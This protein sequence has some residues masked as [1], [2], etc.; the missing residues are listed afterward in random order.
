MLRK[1]KEHDHGSIQ[2]NGQINASAQSISLATLAPFLTTSNVSEGSNLY[3]TNA[4]VLSAKAADGII[5]ATVVDRFG[6]PVSG[7]T[8]YASRTSGTGYFGT[9]VTKIS[10]TTGVAGTAEFILN[11][12]ADVKVSTLSYDAVAGTNASGQTCAPPGQRHGRAGHPAGLRNRGTLAAAQV[13]Q[14]TGTRGT[15]AGHAMAAGRARG[16]GRPSRR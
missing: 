15:A 2:A 7:V 14:P 6:N 11:G 4:R 5:T 3:Y 9:G 12:T 10:T 16:S 1:F 8:V 13:S